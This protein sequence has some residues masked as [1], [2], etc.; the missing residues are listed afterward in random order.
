MLE[1]NALSEFQDFIMTDSENL[2]EGFCGNCQRKIMPSVSNRCMYCG[3]NLPEKYCLDEAGKKAL[4]AEKMAA[5][6]KNEAE[7]QTIIENMRKDF[8]LAPQNKSRKQKRQENQEAIDQ[9]LASINNHFNT[10]QGK[11]DN[12]NE[13]SMPD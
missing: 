9:A 10:G 7:A 5:F 8:Q 13:E 1:N 6:K 3:L 12:K 4:M 2:S 11:P